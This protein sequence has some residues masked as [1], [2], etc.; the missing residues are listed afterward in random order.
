MNKNGKWYLHTPV[1]PICEDCSRELKYCDGRTKYC[2]R[3]REKRYP[4]PKKTHN[5]NPHQSVREWEW[6]TY[7]GIPN[8]M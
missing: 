8:E 2:D 6:N 4:A 3:C 7:T 5:K 1:S